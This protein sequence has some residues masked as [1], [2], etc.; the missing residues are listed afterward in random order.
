MIELSF[1]FALHWRCYVVWFEIKTVSLEIFLAQQ[2]ITLSGNLQATQ[3]A[4]SFWTYPDI[5]LNLL[6]KTK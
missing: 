1:E 4:Q 5:E 6:S 2:C 3:S